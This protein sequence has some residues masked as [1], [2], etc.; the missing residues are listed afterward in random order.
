LRNGKTEYIDKKTNKT[1]NKENY[2][3]GKLKA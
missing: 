2:K 3:E 1:I